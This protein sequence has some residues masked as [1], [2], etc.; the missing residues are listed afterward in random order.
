[1]E[2]KKI[3]NLVLKQDQLYVWDAIAESWYNLRRKPLLPIIRNLSAQWKPGK[4]LDVGCGNCRNTIIFAKHDFDCYGVDFSKEMIRHAEKFSK[5]NKVNIK[6]KVANATTL[7]FRDSSFDYVMCTALLHHISSVQERRKVL[8][9]IKRVLKKNGEALISVWNKLQPSFLFG[10]K[11]KYVGW[12]IGSATY[13]RYHYFFTYWELKKMLK[14]EG[15][16]ILDHSG[17]LGRNIVFIIK[18]E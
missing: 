6:L 11:E 13:Y 7:P 12:R 14:K 16:R 10:G 3:D 2:T 8:S 15:F 9:E 1:M 18:K 17:P 5:E 4:L